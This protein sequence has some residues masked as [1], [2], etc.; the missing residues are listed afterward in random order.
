MGL[1]NSLGEGRGRDVLGARAGRVY[2]GGGGF[3][4]LGARAG[5]VDGGGG[6]GVRFV[7]VDS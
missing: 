4:G 7:G 5:R 1:G 2:G 3:K 6:R